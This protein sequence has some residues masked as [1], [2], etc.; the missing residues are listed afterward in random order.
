MRGGSIVVIA[1][2]TSSGSRLFHKITGVKYGT[3]MPPTGPLSADQIEILKRWLD[4]GAKWPDAV[5]GDVASPPPDP[6]AVR[7]LNAI[8]GGQAAEVR[9]MVQA[10]ASVVNRKGP[11]G[12]TAL[13]YAVLYADAATVKLLLDAGADVNA[14]N[15]VNATALM[16]AAGDLAKTRMLLEAGAEI[17]VRSDDGRTPLTIAA[18]R[19]GSA[20][21]VKLLLDRGA[22]LQGTARSPIADAA[23]G[24][25][26]S[27]A[28]LLAVDSK[29]TGLAAA[30]RSG[31]SKCVE[32]LFERV[33]VTE[34]PAALT[35]A[36]IGGDLAFFRK[37]AAANPPLPPANA[38]GFTI[39]M[40]ATA[41]DVAAPEIVQSLLE[42]GTPVNAKSKAG[43]T[44]LDFALRNGDPRVVSMLRNA[45]AQEG[46][47]APA[48]LLKP[49]PAA[50]VAAA[51]DR[52]LPLLK[53]ADEG[54]LRQAGCVSCHNNNVFAMAL[55]LARR[56]KSRWADEASAARHRQTIGQY[57][58]GWRER[59]LQGIG[60]PGGADTVSY[61][62]VGLA[63]VQYPADPATDALAYFLLGR[64][65]RDGRWRV[66]SHRPPI[67]SSDV[68][69]TA[70]S[71]RG[72]AVYGLQMRKPE[73]DA[74]IQRAANWLE[75]A[76]VRTTEDRAF[77]LLGLHWA[78]RKKS[79]AT[80]TAGAALLKA[81]REDGGWAATDTLS[82]DAYSTGQ[83]M[84]AMR[85]SGVVTA[86]NAAY[87]RAVRYLMNSQQA[88]GSWYVR[89][90][91]I[92]FQP[93]FES[94]FPYGHD[95]WISAAATNW[96]AMGLLLALQ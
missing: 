70:A 46:V 18:S 2:G 17:N 82:S 19:Y 9:E 34:V 71:L 54:F 89:S 49:Q 40:R 86:S 60:I 14:R 94:G 12:I 59:A 81:Q 96:A 68:Q 13:M 42:R 77:Q 87:R 6:A 78:G 50:S 79:G 73:Y 10:D 5:A 76:E 41:R 26:E 65:Q 24:D 93:Y 45:G 67:E 11:D 91:S 28:A 8:R 55:E 44:A 62:L 66:Q 22:K 53:K 25:E 29:A 88:D 85:E 48:P 32:M 4:Q 16:W 36:V 63:A 64:Q 95:Q 69:V 57:I 74:A 47:P 51:L 20:A 38:D 56:G 15:S 3:Q 43:E 92:P 21:V 84:V 52:S 80:A 30:A 33:P 27:L 35:S 61:I 31:C 90:R 7:L 83:A 23:Q 75:T 1:R 72:L 37:F 58:A 39:L